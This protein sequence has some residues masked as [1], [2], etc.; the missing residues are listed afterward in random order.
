MTFAGTDGEVTVT[1]RAFISFQMVDLWARDSLVDHTKEAG[2]DI[3]YV[4]YPTQDAFDPAWKARCTS[5]LASTSGTVVLIGH[6]THES[7]AVIWEIDETLRQGHP[8]LGVRIYPKED[9]AVPVGIRSRD[10]IPWN[11]DTIADR[12]AGWK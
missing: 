12:I 6:S 4:D 11:L 10:V 3:D 1:A 5:R 8:L 2:A 9:H 7:D